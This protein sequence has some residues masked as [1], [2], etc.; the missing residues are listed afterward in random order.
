VS[1]EHHPPASPPPS[2]SASLPSDPL[3]ERLLGAIARGLD[4]LNRLGVENRKLH[5]DQDKFAQQ[6]ARRVEQRLVDLHVAIVEFLDHAKI[7]H[8]IEAEVITGAKRSLDAS[9]AAFDKAIEQSG[10]HPLM[11]KEEI[12]EDSI[13]SAGIRIRWTTIITYA[14][15]GVPIAVKVGGL[16]AAI[17]AAVYKLWEG[18]APYLHNWWSR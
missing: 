4:G 14:R 6:H 13:T 16:I 18:C 8:N 17:A 12:L 2:S 7:S 9:K 15:A 11:T 10:Q 1:E 5:V 3:L